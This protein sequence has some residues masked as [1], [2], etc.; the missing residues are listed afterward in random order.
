MLQMNWIR[1]NFNHAVKYEARALEKH[2]MSLEHQIHSSK[3][4]YKYGLIW[5]SVLT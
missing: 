1:T 2:L 3:S 4:L 5:N